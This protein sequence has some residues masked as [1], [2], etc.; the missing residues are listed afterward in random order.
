MSTQSSKSL[1]LKGRMRSFLDNLEKLAIAMDDAS[2]TNAI[3]ER[4]VE[5]EARVE[6]LEQARG[7]TMP[8]G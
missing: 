4:F 8:Q 1:T 5:L 7:Q 3:F 6:R 2:P